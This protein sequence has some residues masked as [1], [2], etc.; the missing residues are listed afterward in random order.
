MHGFAKTPEGFCLQKILPTA[1]NFKNT[2]VF[3]HINQDSY[4]QLFDVS[5]KFLLKVVY[6][7]SFKHTEL[8]QTVQQLHKKRCPLLQTDASFIADLI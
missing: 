6:M 1:M 5:L 2:D 8:F 7:L 3:P 4:E